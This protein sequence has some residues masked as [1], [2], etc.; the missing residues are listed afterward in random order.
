[1]TL[2]EFYAAVGGDYEDTLKRFLKEER[3]TKW[4]TRFPAAEDYPE[5]VRAIGEERWEEAFR[6]SHNLKGVCLNL[7]L[8]RL[9][10]SSSALC[11][12]MRHGKPTVDIAALSEEVARDYAEAIAMIQTLIAG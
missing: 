7:G 6:F 5:M 4:L 12:T 11:E 2:Q 8:G 1:M 3:M 9:A 10:T